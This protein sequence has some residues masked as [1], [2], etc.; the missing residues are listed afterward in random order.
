MK[1]CYNANPIL[2]KHKKFKNRYEV[3]WQDHQCENEEKHPRSFSNE[4]IVSE[5]SIQRGEEKYKA[6]IALCPNHPET[7]GLDQVDRLMK[8]LPIF[9]MRG[10]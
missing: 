1:C 5:I 7:S 4:W 3:K 6:V 9:D 10:E 8:I 2:V